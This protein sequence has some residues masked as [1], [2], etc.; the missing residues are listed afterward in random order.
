MG[1]PLEAF[2]ALERLF[3]A[4]QALVLRQVVL[5]F[6]GFGANVALVRPLS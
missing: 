1:E 2:G 5:V 3:T 4:V 6:E